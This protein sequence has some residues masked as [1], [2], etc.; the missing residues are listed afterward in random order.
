ME[1]FWAISHFDSPR[2]EPPQALFVPVPHA[3]SYNSDISVAAM[4]LRHQRA[5]L[6]SS[7]VAREIKATLLGLKGA[8]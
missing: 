5:V 6:L 1:S 7:R 2:L 8:G 4:R 3:V